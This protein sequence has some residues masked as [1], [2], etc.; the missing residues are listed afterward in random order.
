LD[1]GGI[2]D[3]DD[4]TFSNSEEFSSG[5]WSSTVLVGRVSFVFA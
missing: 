5:I 4:M 2:I 1:C 3:E